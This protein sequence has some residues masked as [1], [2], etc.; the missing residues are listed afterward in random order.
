MTDYLKPLPKPD[1]LTAPLWDSVNRGKLEIQCCDDCKTY[2][3]YPRGLCPSCGSRSLRWTPVSGRG[4]IHSL[5]IVHRPTNAAFKADV[6]YVV[7][8]IELEE[9]CRLMSNVIGVQPD[10][11]IVKIGMPVEIVYD[12]VTKETVLP[13]FKPLTQ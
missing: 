3:F 2:V 5:T 4:E 13:K 11:K 8:I 1:P 12:R 6:P 7:A 10:P 9:G